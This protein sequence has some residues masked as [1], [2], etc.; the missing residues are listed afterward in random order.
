MTP[1][2]PLVVEIQDQDLSYETKC[3]ILNGIWGTNYIPEELA[4][5]RLGESYLH[6]YDEQCRNA[7]HSAEPE[8]FIRT[9]DD[10]IKIV[11]YLQEHPTRL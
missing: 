3:A 6:Y 5:Q 2:N 8:P 11:H 10:V 9:H 7:L 1:S 4:A